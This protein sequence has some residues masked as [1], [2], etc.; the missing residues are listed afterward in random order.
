[1]AKKFDAFVNE[2]NLQVV[3]SSDAIN[4]RISHQSGSGHIVAMAATGKDL[5][6][7]IESGAS[8]TAIGK[9]IEDTINNQLK[10]LRQEITV[11]IDYGY[12]GAGYAFTLNLEGL[13]KKLNK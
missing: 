10:K 1:M 11:S 3:T 4:Y 8:K 6:K 13:L 5:D 2:K 7:E 9:D 12:Q